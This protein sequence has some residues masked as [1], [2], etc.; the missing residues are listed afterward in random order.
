MRPP[1]TGRGRLRLV[2]A[3]ALALPLAVLTSAC[4]DDPSGPGTVDLI[5]RADVALGAAV[6]ELMGAGVV[7]VEQPAVGWVELVP[8]A[9][10]GSTPVHRLVVVQDAPGELHLRVR[11]ADVAGLLP[12]V[13]VIEAA[14]Q[15]DALLTSLAAVE[16][17]FRR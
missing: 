17:T 4:S 1:R 2:G 6:V 3:L 11:V 15:S 14:D 16:A 9:V 13:T 5:V 7:G 12:T 8:M 10:S